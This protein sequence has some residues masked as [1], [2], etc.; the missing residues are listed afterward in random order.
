MLKN[1]GHSALQIEITVQYLYTL[2]RMIKIQ[3]TDFPKTRTSPN[4]GKDVEKQE[5][6]FIACG[7]AKWCTYYGLWLGSFLRN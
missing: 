2:I 1:V 7:S 3:N 6:S 4:A 5:L